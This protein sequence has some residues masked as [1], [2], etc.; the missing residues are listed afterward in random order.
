MNLNPLGSQLI[1]KDFY[2]DDGVTSVASEE[3][4]I[5]L[6]KQAWQLCASANQ[7]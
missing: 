3:E 4:A 6:A 2:V 5:Q 1:L 7:S